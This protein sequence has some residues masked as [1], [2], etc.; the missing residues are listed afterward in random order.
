MHT[1]VEKVLLVVD[2]AI[3]VFDYRIL[4]VMERDPSMTAI[5]LLML[6]VLLA[7][8][9]VVGVQ[10]HADI[11]VNADMRVPESLDLHLEAL[12]VLEG[13][14]YSKSLGLSFQ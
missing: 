3:R 14:V 4:K 12:T 10:Y 9:K 13:H 1:L 11:I 2:E 6:L 7:A 8:A 5:L